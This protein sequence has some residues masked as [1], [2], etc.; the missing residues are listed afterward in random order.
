MST[1]PVPQNEEQRVAKLKSYNILDTSPEAE[2][3]DLT[4][5]AA[6]ICEVPI[7]LISL[8]DENRQ[9]FKSKVGL[10]APET[11]R[12]I[13]FC[14][15]AIM[16]EKVFEVPDSLKDERFANTPLVTG[17]PK[18]R[19]YSGAPLIDNEGLALGTL[20]VIDQEPKELTDSQRDSLQ[21]IANTVVRMIRLRKMHKEREEYFKLFDLSKDMLCIGGLKGFYK[22]LNPAFTEILGW[23]KEELMSKPFLELVHPDDSVA[24]IQEFEKLAQGKVMNGFI[25]RYRTKSGDYKWLS[26]TCQPSIE[27][28]QL[29]AVAHDVTELKKANEAALKSIRAKDRFLANMSHEIR[30]PLNAII[31]FT[32]LLEGTNM[33]D[34]Q[35]KYVNTIGI[36]SDNLLML[37]NNVLDISKIESGN[38]ELE[39]KV[40]SIKNVMNDVIRLNSQKAK[41][42]GLK[43]IS[44]VDHEIPDY[45]L[46]DSARLMQILLNLMS[47]AVKFTHEGMIELKAF[48]EEASAKDVLVTFSIKDTGIGIDQEKIDKMFERFTQAESSTTRKYG[49]TGLGLSIVKK[50]VELHG[51]TVIV[52]STVGEGTEFIFSIKYPL[53]YA[54]VQKEKSNGH[55]KTG[56][57]ALEGIRILLV[58]DNEH[59]QIL[60]TTY[61]VKNKAEVDLAENGRI[62]VENNNR[63]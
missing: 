6:R 33:S 60:A 54:S 13:S 47:N 14:Q 51:G 52:N 10:D 56:R 26:W 32:D 23:T 41:E 7:C 30:T 46:G 24:T 4:K 37:I 11:A 58:E 61:L 22:N 35:S 18:I 12:D 29:F 43:L 39:K 40:L 20:C 49:G 50:L 57:A 44:S 17:D 34:E 31:G 59:N 53:T 63:A 5:L 9:W 48:S 8:V 45:V 38:L 42:K 3:D 55:E 19:F 21:E 15:H 62:A 28:K 2:F 25:N 16:D 27:T 36:A 1:V